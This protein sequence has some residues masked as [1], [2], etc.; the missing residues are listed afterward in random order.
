MCLYDYIY[1]EWAF[2]WYDKG[3]NSRYIVKPDSPI[4]DST[5]EKLKD[6]IVEL[7]DENT[8]YVIHTQKMRRFSNAV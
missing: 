1:E 4:L 7:D 5:D 6:R 2:P 8:I 3:V